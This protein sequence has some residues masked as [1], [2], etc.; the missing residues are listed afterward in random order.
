MTAQMQEFIDNQ[1]FSSILTL[2]QEP[3]AHIDTVNPIALISTINWD[4]MYF[5]QAMR[6]KDAP[7][8]IEAIMTEMNDRINR[9]HGNLIPRSEVSNGHKVLPSVRSMKRKRD[10][11]TNQFYK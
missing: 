1:A 7:Q 5:N 3:E 6:E 8:F 11:L 9:K 4:T 2:Y 10:N